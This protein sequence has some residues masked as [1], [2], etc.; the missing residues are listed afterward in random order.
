MKRTLAFLSCL[1]LIACSDRSLPTDELLGEWHA[2][3]E[4][5]IS[6]PRNIG[7]M[8][9]SEQLAQMEDYFSTTILHFTPDKALKTNR[10]DDPSTHQWLTWRLLDVSSEAFEI[11][12]IEGETIAKLM[13]LKIDKCIGL[14]NESPYFVEHFCRK[15]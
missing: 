2:V 8:L 7:N 3:G 12:I 14:V 5:T 6:D 4:L 10:G 1:L 9:N 11:E 13:L 15:P